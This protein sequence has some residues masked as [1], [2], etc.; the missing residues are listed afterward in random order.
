ML[1][2]NS[3]GQF[4][5]LCFADLHMLDAN[6]LAG[7]DTVS[8]MNGALDTLSPDLVVFLGD[9]IRQSDTGTDETL[10]EALNAV[11]E[12]VKSRGIPLATVFGNHDVETGMPLDEQLKIYRS[13]ENCLSEKGECQTGVGNYNV[14]VK[15][16]AGD[17]DLF[18]LW[19]LDSGTDSSLP[20]GSFSYDYVADDQIAW[21]EKTAAQLAE[22]NRGYMLPAILF[23]HIPVPEIYRLLKQVPP[24]TPLS[25]K[26]NDGRWY[27][28]A[29]PKFT[30]GK[31]GEGPCPPR[32]NNGQFES[33]KKTDDILGAVFGHD[34]INDFTGT[35][36][37]ITL[38][39]TRG[40]GFEGYGDGM[41]RGVRL[42]TLDESDLT[43]F[44][45]ETLYYKDVVTSKRALSVAPADT[46]T[47]P[48]KRLLKN[49]LG[50]GGVVAAAGSAVAVA[51]TAIVKRH[52]D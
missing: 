22:Q 35:V 15:N 44:K 3:D 4:K 9:V 5:I 20:D 30:T 28:I 23:Q 36:D 13:Y 27:I 26:G 38:M 49:G 8:L 24:I 17:R 34:H 48:Q 1:K 2:F 21:Y 29:E 33:W 25:V 32:V 10:R 50:I 43:T 18:N 6:S 16:A 46:L 51:V 39:Q 7:F 19:F 14:T 41:L 11:I 42:I 37:G 52:K 45:T 47:R 40:A 12:P 31:L